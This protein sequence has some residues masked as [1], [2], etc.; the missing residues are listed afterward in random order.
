MSLT[1]D[2]ISALT[3]EYVIP[4]L[5]NIVFRDHPLLSILMKKKKTF[6]GKQIEPLLEYGDPGLAQF[7]ERMKPFTIGESEI[8]TTAAFTP[9]M[10]TVPLAIPLEEM[11]ENSGE[12][13]IMDIITAKVANLKNSINVKA[14]NRLFSRSATGTNEWAS[15]DD[16]IGTGACGGIT[17][18]DLGTASLWQSHLI[19]VASTYTDDP[20]DP[21]NLVNKDSDVYLYK[22]LQ[23]GYAKA[24]YMGHKP[25][26]II[27]SQNMF[28]LIDQV[29]F[30]KLNGSQ[31]SAS[32]ADFG[33]E[34]LK[35]RSSKIVAEEDITANQ[36]SDID[37][38]IYFLNTD[39]FYFFFNSKATFNA[40][41]FV[42]VVNL[43]ADVMT[44]H[45]FGNMVITNRAAQCMMYNL[46]SKKEYAAAA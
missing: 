6:N 12:G 5:Q 7:T 13:K 40:E 29:L 43:N 28:D 20:G 34:H 22:L 16:L 2:T 24:S 38:R 18:A 35:F 25:D 46:Y 36:T 27:C 4:V 19:D 10:M 14:A 26:L 37:S 11:L 8:I 45:A 3:Q 23:R 17:P 21:A 31:L 9:K 33:F 15:L 30:Q 39:F 41:P 1:K 42:R 44:I 32:T